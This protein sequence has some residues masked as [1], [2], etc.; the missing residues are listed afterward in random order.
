MKKIAAL[1]E[2]HHVGFAPHNPNGPVATRVCQH[3]DAATPNFII[4]EWLPD[5]GER[6]EVPWRDDLMGGSFEIGEGYMELPTGP[7]LGID[8]NLEVIAAHPYNPRD[9]NLYSRP[10]V[11]PRERR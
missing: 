8:L 6:R 4:Q 1:A 5:N 7:G 3:L 11:V 2:S 9:M 10:A